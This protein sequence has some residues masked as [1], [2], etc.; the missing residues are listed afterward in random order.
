M[1]TPFAWPKFAHLF[2]AV[3]TAANDGVVIA[4]ASPATGPGSAKIVFVNPAFSRMTGYAFEEIVGRTP[5]LLQGPGTC[6][7]TLDRVARAVRRREPVRAELLNYRK[8]GEAYWVELNIVP[9]R[10]PAGRV[11]HFASIE[12]DITAHKRMEQQLQE[13][14]SIDALTGLPNRRSFMARLGEE[15][16]RVQRYGRQLAFLSLDIDHFKRINDTY[17]HAAGD[18]ALRHVA[19]VC[20]GALRQNDL[21]GRLG[22][23]EFGVLVPETN[24]FGAELL[25]NRMRQRVAASPFKFGRHLLAMTV[26]IGVAGLMH[27]GESGLAQ[28]LRDADEAMYRAKS[29]GRNRVMVAPPRLGGGVAVA[30]PMASATIN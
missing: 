19:Q 13:L 2:E 4:K 9:L 11:T 7:E 23:E 29:A 27:G 22:G 17:G 5:R 10:G 6:R 8:D 15:V 26:S 16:R 30:A 3:I 28:L 18:E 25:A 14:A 12:R 20:S 1:S 21:C 24:L